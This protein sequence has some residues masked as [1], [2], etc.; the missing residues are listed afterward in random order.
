MPY[1]YPG[2]YVQEIPSGVHSVTGV[3]T[4]TAAFIDFFPE[5]PFNQPVNIFSFGDFQRIYGGL[6]SRSEAGYAISQF[7][8]NGGSSAYVVRTA[9]DDSADGHP[10]QTASAFLK[11]ADGTPILQALAASPGIWGNTLRLDVDYNTKDPATLFNLTVTRYDSARPGAAPVKSETFLNL[12]MD[13]ANSRFAVNVIKAESKLITLAKP[14]AAA[15]VK[16]PPAE[17]G[18]TS[19]DLSGFGLTDFNGLIGKSVGIQIGGSAVQPAN[20]TWGSGEVQSLRDLAKQLEKAINKADTTSAAFTTARVE[21]VADKYL[22][23]R[24]GRQSS[25]YSPLELVTSPAADTTAQV[26]KLLAANNACVNVQEYVLGGSSAAGALANDQ[27]GG[28]GIEPGADE[29]IGVRTDPCTGMYALDYADI[30]NILCMPR[31][32]NLGSTEMTSVVATALAYCQ[33]KRAFML[34]DIPES[35]AD[36]EI[37]KDW[38]QANAGLRHPNASIHYPRLMQP[39]PLNEYRPKSVGPSGTLAGLFA[40]I[41]STRGVWKAP[42]GTEAVLQ[43]VTGLMDE[44]TDMQNGALNPLGINCFRNFPIYGM[45]N[46]GG[47][48]LHGS[49]QQASEWKYIPVRRLALF[50]EESLFRGTP[51]VV[52]EPNDEPLWAK[53]RL[54]LNAFMSNLFR[55]GAFQGSTP[56]QAYY[57]K[58]DGD[59]TTQDD[60]NHGIVNIEVGFAPLK[61]AE[62][63]VLKFQQIAGKL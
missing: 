43:G 41:D 7:F 31:T 13:E 39:D 14:H 29:L 59:T 47:R 1:T 50:M 34:I 62:F 48:T 11:T 17:T 23:I 58:C 16:T 18:L 27:I 40:R 61:P 51:W 3:S 10:L 22:R 45:V 21:T 53:I 55:Q 42:A 26:L 49:D 57:V 60:R 4:S 63:V 32:A 12:S 35:V 33:E 36:L 46:W 44:L 38:I 24:S 9:K 19:G 15:S 56:D 8:L 5:G 52:F 20:L 54:N 30:F 28:D 37:M 2:V 25:T 6:D